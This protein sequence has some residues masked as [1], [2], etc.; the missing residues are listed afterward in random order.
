[1]M[2]L[3]NDGTLGTFVFYLVEKFYGSWD[4]QTMERKNINKGGVVQCRDS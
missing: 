1:M 3:W 4:K 2:E